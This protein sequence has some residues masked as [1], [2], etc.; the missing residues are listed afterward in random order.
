[1]KPTSFKRHRFPA[2]VIG[3]E[4]WLYFSLSL[5]FRDVEE[6]MVAEGIGVSYE[7]I[8]CWTIKFGPLIARLLK[9]RRPPPATVVV[10]L[11]SR[12]SGLSDRR[13]AHVSLARCRR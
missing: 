4:V 5:S 10:P 11:A 7:A 13:K 3:Q 8:R 1:V 9:R 2:D 6:R 12:R